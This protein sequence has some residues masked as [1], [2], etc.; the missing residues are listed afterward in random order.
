MDMSVDGKKRTFRLT[1]RLEA[2][3]KQV[4]IALNFPDYRI[5]VFAKETKPVYHVLTDWLRGA[6]MEEDRRPLTWETLITA[7]QE[8][9]LHEE[10]KLLENHLA[11]LSSSGESLVVTTTTTRIIHMS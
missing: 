2:Y 1:D 11:S 5:R 7:L 8:A 6:N 9:K 10:A 4:A 3:W